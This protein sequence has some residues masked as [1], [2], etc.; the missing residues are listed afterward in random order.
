MFFA[1][2]K[3]VSRAVDGIRQHTFGIV[4][5]GFAVDLHR[6][7]ERMAFIERIPTEYLNS[8]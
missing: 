1:V 2:P 7:L 4:P 5:V 6:I 3:V 8:Q